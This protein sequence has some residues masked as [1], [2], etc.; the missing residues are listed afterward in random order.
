MSP[1]SWIKRF[2]PRGLYGRAALILIVPVLGVQ[3]VVSSVFIQRHY[4]NVTEQMARALALDMNLVL[5]RFASGGDAAGRAT[6]EALEIELAIPPQS[7]P[8]DRRLFYDLSGVVMI[9][10]MRSNV[11]GVTAVDLVNIDDDATIS[12]AAGAGHPAMDMTV[13]RRRVSASNPHQLLVI[14]GF[15]GIFMTALAYLFLRNQLRPIRRLAKAAEAFGKG[16]RVE[17]RPAG[18]TEVRSAG[19]AFLDMR[20]RIENQIEQRTLMLSGVSHDLRTPLTRMRLGLSMMEDEQGAADLIR[21]VEEMEVLLNTF[22]DFARGEA[23]DDPVETDVVALANRVVDNARRAGGQ[24]TYDGPE[25]GDR[26]LMRPDAVHR[27]LTN[28]IGNAL[29]YGDRAVLSLTLLEGALRFTIEDDGPGIPPEDRAAAVRPF[30]RLDSA[31]NQDR[32][33]GVG[34]GLAI[35]TDIARR[36]GG[37]LRLAESA[38]LGGLRVDLVLPR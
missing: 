13:S 6:A 37:T 18:A 24:V 4:E 30:T 21:D 31:R 38:R 25:R 20:N 27:A 26:V 28:L 14:M 32:G 5:E 9:D 15:T 29:R 35:A 12:V 11:P 10:V 3:L 16:R 33:T 17:Y 23:L 19:R 22:L 2:L 8:G 1:F 34:L 36:H 7:E